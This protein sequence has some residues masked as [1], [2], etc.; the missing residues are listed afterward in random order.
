HV[1]RDDEL[2]AQLIEL[3]REFWQHVVDGTP[4]PV[5]GSDDARE[6]LDRLYPD[7]DPESVAVLPPDA[8]ELIR[9]YHEAKAAEKAA[10]ERRQ[11]AE[12]RLKALLG[13][14]AIGRL[15]GVD[16]VTWK[17]VTQSRIDTKRLKAEKPGIYQQ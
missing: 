1:D 4:P 6:L 13:D 7:A 14:R 15:N 11:E 5:D 16:V 2:I 9:A 10:A 8:E 12:N 17:P 3:E